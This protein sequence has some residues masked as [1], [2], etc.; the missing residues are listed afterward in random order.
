M[1]YS[2]L[3]FYFILGAQRLYRKGIPTNLEQLPFISV[4]IPVKNEEALLLNTLHSLAQQN[5]KGNWE[6]I[7]VNDGSTDK[8]PEILENFCKHHPRFKTFNI[9]T[10]AKKVPSPKKRALALGFSEAGGE[11]LMTSDADCVPPSGWLQSMAE[12]FSQSIGI[13]QGPKAIAGPDKIIT[14]YQKLE[15]FGFVSIE[16]ATF[17]MGQPMIASA[18]SLAYRKELYERAGGF[19]GLEHL[20]SG[21]DDMLVHKIRQLEK[22]QVRYNLDATA[23]VSTQAVQTWRSLI[24]QRARWASN[25]SKYQNKKFVM[26]LISI[27]V[28]YLWL[29]GGPI[30]LVM[31]LVSPV[32]VLVPW[33]LY[34]SLSF[35]FLFH[36]S[37]KF[38]QKKLLIDIWWAGVIHIPIIII[39]TVMGQLGLFKWK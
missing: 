34:Y 12:N 7:C 21:D 20:V 23:T 15:V 29:M 13:V 22:V 35:I 37:H 26:L 10:N 4:V 2:G 16:A 9:D 17:A 14:R 31:H 24:N 33:I 38:G 3:M 11:V 39:A 1:I 30:A 18:P 36:T 28:F 25:G 27:F 32:Y 19:E 5:Y 8:T 6:V